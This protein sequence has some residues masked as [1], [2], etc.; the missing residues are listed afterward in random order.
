MRMDLYTKI[1]LTIIAICL[2]RLSVG[3]SLPVVHAQADSNGIVHVAIEENHA[4]SEV[5]IRG[6]EGVMPVGLVGTSQDA[7]GWNYDQSI[8]I[9]AYKPLPV[10]LDGTKFNVSKGTW[11][12]SQPI[13]VRAVEADKK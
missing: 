4:V 3:N 12:F 13:F 2:V 10:G 6:I 1:V 7:G 9:A 8:P 11:D 5:R